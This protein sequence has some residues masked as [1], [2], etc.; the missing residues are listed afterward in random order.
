M[1]DF[2]TAPFRDG[3]DISVPDTAVRLLIAAVLG[4]LVALVYRRSRDEIDV[5]PTFPPTLVLLSVLI[6]MVTQVIGSNVARAFS[7]VGALAIVRFRTVVRDTQDTAYVI[8]AVVVGMSVGAGAPWVGVI[9]IGVSACVVVLMRPKP[10]GDYIAGRLPLLVRVRV[11]LGHDVEGLLGPTL[12]R[13]FSHRRMHSIET[14]KQGI[15]IDVEYEAKLRPPST[16]EQLV[17]ELNRIDG[18]QGVR[19]ERCPADEE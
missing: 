10:T 19:V 15:S 8:L 17:R 14:A 11:G 3:P 9:G 2:L 7:L 1:L 4:G 5:A 13:H 12:D 18:V 16:P 6:A